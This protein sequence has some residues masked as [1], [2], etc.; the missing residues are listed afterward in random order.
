[1]NNKYREPSPGFIIAI[2]LIATIMAAAAFLIW[3]LEEP[4]FNQVSWTATER[5]KTMFGKDCSCVENPEED[6]QQAFRCGAGL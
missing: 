3:D 1:M 5:C 2:L 4:A 6:W